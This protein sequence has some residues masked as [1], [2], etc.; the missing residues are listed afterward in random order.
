MTTSTRERLYNLLP[1]VYRSR[2]VAEGEPLRALCALI[3]AELQLVDDDIDHLYDNLFIE[4][5]AEWVVPYIGDLLGARRLHPIGSGAVSLRAYVANTLAHRRR[6][7][8]AAVLEQLARDVTG[9]PARAVE[10]FQLLATTQHLIHLRAGNLRTP[11]LRDTNPLELLDGPFESAARTVEVRHIENR[12]GRYNIPNIGLFLWRLQSYPIVPSGSSNKERRPGRATARAVAE[13]ADG[14]YTFNPLGYDA[15]LFN[16]PQTEKEITHLAEEINVP[17]SLRRRALY[18]ELEARRQAL[19]NG[20]EPIAVYFTEKQPVFEVYIP[21][22]EP[23]P[24]EEIVICDLTDWRRPPSG[25]IAVDP[26]LGRLAFPAGDTPDPVLVS[27]S[28]GFSGDV[29]GGPYNRNESVDA[30]QLPERPWQVGVSKEHT[31]VTNDVFPT[32][33][34]AVNAWNN[35]PDGTTGMIAILDSRTYTEDLT[36]DNIIIIKPGSRLLIVAADWPLVPDPD[37]PAVKARIPGQLVPDGRRPH[38]LGD[39][40]VRGDGAASS[41]GGGLALDGLLIEGRVTVLVGNLLQLRLAHCTLVPEKGGHTERGSLTV[42]PSMLPGGRN[43]GLHIKVER[44]ICGPIDL[45]DSPVPQ[46]V[47]VDS[48]VEA[49]GHNADPAIDGLG[50]AI[51]APDT[52]VDVQMSTVFGESEMRSLEAGNSIFTGKLDAHRTQVGCVRF[53]SVPDGSRTPRRYAC[54]PDLALKDAGA[55][56]KTGILLRLGPAFT[57][58]RYGHPAYAQ[59]GRTCAEEISTGAEDGSEMGVFSHLKQPQRE[60]NIRTTLEEYLPFGLEAGILYVT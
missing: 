59:L 1:A 48:V 30:F 13:P 19:A 45:R 18:D 7:G 34:E 41:G 51:Y 44:S 29:G 53:S 15:P 14:R 47:I 12:R 8:T 35:Q 4:T 28:Y 2:D 43:S 36:G 38:L 23:A 58:T 31:S 5:C 6:K 21:G 40:S 37:S 22:K 57:S 49:A 26:V 17:D 39:L 27:Y 3:E 33:V 54:Q 20:E 16:R 11:D 56:E 55:A 46:L 25:Q 42:S 10:F 52:A 24:P 32:L 60:A 9:W 50:T